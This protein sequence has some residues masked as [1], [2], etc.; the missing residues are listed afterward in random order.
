VVAMSSWFSAGMMPSATRKTWHSVA[1]QRRRTPV[2]RG[3]ILM[4]SLTTLRFAAATTTSTIA[5]TIAAEGDHLVEQLAHRVL[6][7]KAA[8]RAATPSAG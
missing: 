6:G 2:S 5:T 7:A 1:Q 8:A 3:R 4:R